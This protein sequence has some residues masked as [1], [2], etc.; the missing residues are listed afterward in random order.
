M[1]DSKT[2]A[3][4][5]SFQGL[6]LRHG[7]V[8]CLLLAPLIAIGIAY[9]H[10]PSQHPVQENLF[11]GVQY[12]R[13]FRSTPRPQVIHLVTLDLGAPGIKPFVTPPL[14]NDPEQRHATARTTSAFLQE[15]GLQ[16]A[17]N[18]SFFYHFR[19]ETPWDYFPHPGQRVWVMGTAISNRV[20]YK[21]TLRGFPS[22]CFT[23]QQTARIVD[24]GQCPT[25]TTQAISG[26]E[27]FVRQGQLIQ[28]P[29]K[30]AR[31]WQK[32]YPRTAIATDTT[33]RKL[34]IILVDGKQPLYSEGATM[35]ELAAIAIELG[36]TTALNLDGGGSVTLAIGNRNRPKV[37]N[38]PIQSK[39]PT[40]ERPIANH[41]GFYTR[42]IRHSK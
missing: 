12:T 8:F 36:A 37:L 9:F 30:R 28:N 26:N 35:A 29:S 32:P 27:I 16:L 14:E 20:P 31:D 15:F 10:R 6:T 24:N 11:E 25:Q 22:I 5:F 7:L 21:K 42:P 40:W 13:R 2:L 34:W 1:T 18:G 39:I 17:V 3:Y 23:D 4:P 33:G 38:A 41:L 19:E